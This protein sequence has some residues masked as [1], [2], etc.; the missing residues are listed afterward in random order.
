M[1]VWEHENPVQA[2]DAI[3]ALWRSRRRPPARRKEGR[4]SHVSCEI[5][6]DVPVQ[7]G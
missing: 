3:E 7:E 2:A 4:P 6:V 5:L 1:H